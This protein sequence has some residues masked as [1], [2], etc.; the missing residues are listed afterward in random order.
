MPKFTNANFPMTENG[1]TY[2][3]GTKRHDVASRILCVG[4]PN[5]A[6][7]L[8]TLF[9]KP[10]PLFEKATKRGFTT[11]TGYYKGKPL[12][13]VAT[14]MGFPMTDFFVRECRAVVDGPMLICRFGSCG[15]ISDRTHVGNMA[16]A[17]KGSINII[18][19]VDYFSALAKGL[20]HAGPPY[21]ISSPEQADPELSQC[22]IKSLSTKL[23]TPV[24][25]CMNATACSFYS[26]QGR[27][28]PSFLDENETLI[29]DI[30]KSHPECETL[31]M[32][33]YQ[34]L[35]LA[36][37]S[38]GKSIRASACTMIFAG[39]KENE[40]ITPEQVDELEI[41]AGRAI[42]DALITCSLPGEVDMLKGSPILKKAKM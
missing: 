15:G 33:S 3:V 39:R 36:A 12:S 1:E 26:S 16:V 2:H 22:L 37:C 40:F 35:H 6:K 24:I 27:H 30:R 20:K 32:E 29:E 17:T 23:R 42:L 41:T 18:R 7:T 4:D 13:I 28:D 25:P 34:L 31:E 21:I 14:G 10:G 38:T 5:R 11:F 19:N 8:S 9:D